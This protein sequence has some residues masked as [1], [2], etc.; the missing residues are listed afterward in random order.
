MNTR[1]DE[2]ESQQQKL[3]L[4][5]KAESNISLM[6][7]LVCNNKLVVVVSINFREL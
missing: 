1:R 3:N 5:L 7:G 4:A 6:T 2:C